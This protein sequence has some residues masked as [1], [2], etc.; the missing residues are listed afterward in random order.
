MYVEITIWEFLGC[1]LIVLILWVIGYAICSS[2]KV[3]SFQK[4]AKI[5]SEELGKYQKKEQ[6]KQKPE[7]SF[8]DYS[9]PRV[10]KKK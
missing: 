2:I 7:P 1:S 10:V 8:E 4:I 6:E 3:A 9:V 5:S